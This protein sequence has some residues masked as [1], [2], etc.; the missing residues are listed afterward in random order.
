MPARSFPLLQTRI[1]AYSY[2]VSD[3]V[4]SKFWFRVERTGNC[5][6]ITRLQSRLVPEG[7]RR[8]LVGG[9]LPGARADPKM[10]IVFRDIARDKG[11]RRMP[12][13]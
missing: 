12:R 5:D 11:L 2:Q 3:A 4:D 7:E 13:P 10:A 9:V 8:G 1:D 6:V